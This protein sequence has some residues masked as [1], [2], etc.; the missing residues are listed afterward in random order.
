M[1][2][3][4]LDVLICGMFYVYLNFSSII[5]KEIV[6]LGFKNREVKDGRKLFVIN[7]T[8]I[9]GILIECAFLLVYARLLKMTILSL[10]L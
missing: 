8:R 9:P 7:R 10:I 1:Q 5:L 2:I 3:K 6:K 4:L